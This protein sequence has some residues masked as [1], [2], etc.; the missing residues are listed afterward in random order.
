MQDLIVV[1]GGEH[2]RVVIEAAQSVPERWRILGFIDPA[3]C[4]ETASRMRLPRLGDHDS[5]ARYSQ[6]AFVL[7][8]GSRGI[9]GR[10]RPVVEQ[11]GALPARWAIVIHRTAW[12]SPTADLGAGS[13]VFAGAAIN[14]GA[15]IGSHCI[16]NTHACV[17]HDAALGDFAHAGPGSV[18]A[19]GARVGADSY[20]GIGSLVR[21]HRTIGRNCLVGMGAA[22]TTNYGDGVTL[23]GVPARPGGKP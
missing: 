14:T 9:D 23:L 10:R 20:L 15:R 16:V 6:A 4:E 11:I 19:G 3:P 5:L 7:G 21:D 12:V 1:G 13:V 8:V 18:V 2:A 22:V 17:E